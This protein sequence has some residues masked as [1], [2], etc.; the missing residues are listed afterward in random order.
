VQ[1][2]RVVELGDRYVLR[3]VTIG[4]EL[5]LAEREAHVGG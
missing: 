2:Q 5:E 4:G 1:E 3:A